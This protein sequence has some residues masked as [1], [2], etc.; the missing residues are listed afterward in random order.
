MRARQL[1]LALLVATSL[2]TSV[3]AADMPKR[4][5]ALAIQHLDESTSALRWSG[6][7]GTFRARA[8]KLNRRGN[9]RPTTS[10]ICTAVLSQAGPGQ[11]SVARLSPGRW[12][13]QV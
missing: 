1:L 9:P 8:I 4:P 6:S 12:R 2:P 10:R 11:C 7:A 3:Q 13:I 5:S